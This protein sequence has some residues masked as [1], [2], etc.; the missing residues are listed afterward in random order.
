MTT[1]IGAKTSLAL[2]AIM[3]LS[4][5]GNGGAGWT[6]VEA[7]V[8]A[9]RLSGGGVFLVNVHVPDEGQIPG[10]D[11]FIPYT[12]IAS[13]MD[14]LPSDGSL[15]IY[16]RSGNMSTEA[17]QELIDRGFTAFTELEGGYV[18]WREAGLP[19]DGP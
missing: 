4:A 19:F 2:A 14:E 5:C 16:C 15:V 3:A 6:R 8:L 10:T 13:R 9:E 18:A 11:A 7:P 17:A 1:R 12:E